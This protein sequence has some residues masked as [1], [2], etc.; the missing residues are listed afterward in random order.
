MTREEYLKTLENPTSKE[1]QDASQMP[2]YHHLNDYLWERQRME[3]FEQT[4]RIDQYLT[5]EDYQAFDKNF[6]KVMHM[7]E[8]VDEE[9]KNSQIEQTI[10]MMEVTDWKW[11]LSRGI[12]VPNKQELINNIKYCYEVAL[13]DGHPR[14]SCATGGINVE[15]DI[16]GHAVKVSFNQFDESAYDD[17]FE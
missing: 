12:V 15:I 7:L 13:R 8:Y 1:E 10:K 5:A 17:G 14:Y 3:Y 2:P 6:K 16:Y 4:N 9:Y 11:S